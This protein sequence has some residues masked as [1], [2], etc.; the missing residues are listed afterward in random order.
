[1]NGRIVHGEPAGREASNAPPV[2]DDFLNWKVQ[3]VD[4]ELHDGIG[5]ISILLWEG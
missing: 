1:M 2:N 5:G 3:L 4:S